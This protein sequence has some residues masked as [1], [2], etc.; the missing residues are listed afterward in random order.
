MD[1]YFENVSLV[2]LVWKWKWHLLA[3]IIG[4]AIL[5][6]IFSGP[7]FITPKY[8]SRAVI[9]PSN[10]APYSE[11]SETEQ[12]L[13]WLHSRDIKDSVI[14]R[15][16]LAEH[17]EID[18]GYK[19]YYSTMLWEY[20]QNVSISKTQYE[21]I[22][23]KVLDKDPKKAKD[24]VD[25][26]IDL[27]NNKIQRMH[28]DKYREVVKIS[29]R[30]LIRKEK[31]LDSIKEK[32][33]S[34]GIEHGIY[35]VEGQSKEVT[36]GFLKTVD[37][38]AAPNYINEKGVRQLNEA[39]KSRGGEFL[40]HKAYL[41]HLMGRYNELKTEYEEALR[42]VKKEFTFTNAVTT[43]YVSDKK[44]YPTRWLIVFYA[45]AAA[46]F[47]AVVVIA[48]LEKQNKLKARDQN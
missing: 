35:D 5:A 14:Q 19:H 1:K 41:S 9:Y 16:N 13:Q 18:T 21:S 34:F 30:M 46:L 45:V 11:E 10:I 47:L 25:E 36:E 28:R 23:I 17:Y 40:M 31:E 2:T 38:D 27:V 6:A 8:K 32:M 37:S 7:Y 4:A 15:F 12:L 44:D 22:E 33:R 3:T 26:I 39:L 24:M 43:P 20:D 42:N 29:R 48:I